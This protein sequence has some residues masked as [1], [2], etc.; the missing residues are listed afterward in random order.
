MEVLII[1]AT[2]VALTVI[3]L[4]AMSAA[5]DAKHQRER[6]LKADEAEHALRMV[7]AQA[8][9]KLVERDLI[10]ARTRETE[11]TRASRYS[12]DSEHLTMRYFDRYLPTPSQIGPARTVTNE[13]ELT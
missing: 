8:A 10:I 9:A 7:E 13:K 4:V 6:Q 12:Q 3:V 11:L 2:V 5:D 1:C